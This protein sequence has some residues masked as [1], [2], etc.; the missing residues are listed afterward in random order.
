MRTWIIGLF[1]LLAPAA[2]KAVKTDSAMT[3]LAKKYLL[4]K[5][6][7]VESNA[8]A[9]QKA[10]EEL[11]VLIK[12][13]SRLKGGS[14]LKHAQEIAAGSDLEKQR[15]AF[16]NLSVSFRKTI[17]NKNTTGM[18]LYYMYCPMK[19]A[20]WLSA[21]QAV[22]NPYYGSKMLSCGSVKETIRQ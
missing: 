8:G 9:A 22:R 20:W 19:K 13:N 14:L 15:S 10:A 3:A 17:G 2:A 18:T 16:S 7:L 4:V 12:N 6:A 1:L 5:D 11:A 21:E